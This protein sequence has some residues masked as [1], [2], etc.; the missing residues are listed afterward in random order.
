MAYGMLYDFLMGQTIEAYKY[1]GPHFVK[2]DNKEGV[3]FR[4][5]APMAKEVCVIGEFNNWN[6]GSHLMKK[7]DDSGVYEIFVEGA[8]DYQSYKYHILTCE[9]KYVDKQDPFGVFGEYRPG[10]CSRLFNIENFIWHDD[11]YLKQRTR[12]FDK[13]MSIY[14]L[15]VGSWLDKPENRFLSYEEVADKLIEYVLANGYTHVELMPITQYPFDGSWGY[16]VT[17]F[18]AVDSR[19]GNPFQL[20]SFIDRLH[21]AGIGVIL[22]YVLVHFATDEYGLSKFDGSNLYECSGE[23]EFSQWGS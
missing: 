10:S 5:Y 13:A 21:Q 14:E 15:H 3:L 4:V 18:Y 1:F 6:P 8:K 16:Q 20:M 11:A 2:K 17:G 9:G 23:N 12:N 19:Y 22:D 7:I